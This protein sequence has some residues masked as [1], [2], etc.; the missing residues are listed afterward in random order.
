MSHRRARRGAAAHTSASAAIAA[1]S[2][3][4]PSS[5]RAYRFDVLTDYGAFR[6]LQR[7]R[8]LTLDWQ[9]LTHAPRLHASPKRSSKRGEGR[10][11]R[12]VMDAVGRFARGACARGLAASPSTRVAMAYRVRFYMDM[13]A[14]EAMHVIELRTA[15]GP[16]C[17]PPRLPADAPADRG[18]GR[19][20]R[21]RR[22]DAVRRSFRGRAR[23]LERR[24][25][26]QTEARRARSGGTAQ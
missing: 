5:A 6:D 18:T 20:P 12:R 15:P 21:H 13:N 7:H 22:R 4:A 8:L 11:W 3:A 1:T 2:P 23:A 16:S 19:A 25:R 10:D 14:R 17:V 9:A 26:A 24:A